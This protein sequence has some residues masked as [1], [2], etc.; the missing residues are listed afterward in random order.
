MKS[1]DFLDLNLRDLRDSMPHLLANST[2]ARHFL[3]IFGGVAGAIVNTAREFGPDAE[4]YATYNVGKMLVDFA[5][6][7]DPRP[8]PAEP[9]HRPIPDALAGVGEDLQHA[10]DRVARS[11]KAA[12]HMAKSG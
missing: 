11:R 1:K 3:G 7:C 2:S 6:E 9:G 8:I 5:A 12:E 4:I 10:V